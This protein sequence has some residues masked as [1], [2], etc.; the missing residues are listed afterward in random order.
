[1][2]ILL[3]TLMHIVWDEAKRLANVR[4]HALDFADAAR[5]FSG[6]TYTFEDRR[7][8]YTEFRFVTLGLLYDVVVAIA[9]TETPTQLRIISM[10][11]ATRYEQTIFFENS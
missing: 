10:R 1:M 3:I 6:S 11:K 8:S 4:K 9:H 2:C 7:F 5:V